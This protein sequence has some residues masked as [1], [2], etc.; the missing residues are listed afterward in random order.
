[1]YN[2]SSTKS[3]QNLTSD[4]KIPIVYETEVVSSNTEESSISIVPNE[5][6]NKIEVVQNLETI[7]EDAELQVTSFAIPETPMNQ[8]VKITS[9]Q[10]VELGEN[11]KSK[12][13]ETP[14]YTKPM[15]RMRRLYSRDDDFD[16]HSTPMANKNLN[17]PAL[18]DFMNVSVDLENSNFD[19]LSTNLNVTSS[20]VQCESNQSHGSFDLSKNPYKEIEKSRIRKVNFKDTIDVKLMTPRPEVTQIVEPVLPRE[21]RA[22]SKVNYAEISIEEPSSS[23]SVI[24][25]AKSKREKSK[26]RSENEN[27]P[28]RRK[29]NV[30][31]DEDKETLKFDE[32]RKNAI[33][34]ESHEK[35][36]IDEP[37]VAKDENRIVTDKSKAKTKAKPKRTVGRRGKGNVELEAS[38][39]AKSNQNTVNTNA[40]ENYENDSKDVENE[41]ELVTRKIDDLTK[42]SEAVEE[43]SFKTVEQSDHDIVTDGDKGENSTTETKFRGRGRGKK[44]IKSKAKENIVSEDKDIIIS[45]SK[46]VENDGK[47]DH[48]IVDNKG[49]NSSV[50]V[51]PT[52]S[53]GRGRGKKIVKS[54]NQV[55]V[56]TVS[57]SIEEASLQKNNKDTVEKKIETLPDVSKD[58]IEKSRGIGRGRKQPVQSTVVKAVEE[59][60]NVSKNETSIESQNVEIEKNIENF[61]ETIELP[62]KQQLRRGRRGKTAN[63]KITDDIP[64]S[65]SNDNDVIDVTKS[66]LIESNSTITDKKSVDENQQFEEDIIV[67]L[68]PIEPETK[69]RARPKKNSF[70]EVS[71]ANLESQIIPTEKTRE[72]SVENQD[73]IASDESKK[74]K[75]VPTA[76]KGRGRKANQINTQSNDTTD[77]IIVGKREET[78]STRTPNVEIAPESTSIITRKGKP[79]ANDEENIKIIENSHEIVNQLQVVE[80]ATKPV[81][82]LRGRAAK[83][84]DTPAQIVIQENAKE[85]DQSFT[86]K[87]TKPVPKDSRK[88]RG[89]KDDVPHDIEPVIVHNQDSNT[90]IQNSNT[91]YHH[92][93][94]T[95]TNT[96]TKGRG[97]KID[98]SHDLDSN[99]VDEKQELSA[100]SNISEN[101]DLVGNRKRVAAKGGR[102]ANKIVIK[103]QATPIEP[104]TSRNVEVSPTSVEEIKGRKGRKLIN[105]D[106]IETSVN[107]ESKTIEESLISL[108]SVPLKRA[109]K[110]ITEIALQ[111]LT[112]SSTDSP[113]RSQRLLNRNKTVDTESVTSNHNKVELADQAKVSHIDE[114]IT[115][116]KNNRTKRK[117]N[118][119]EIKTFSPPKRRRQ[120]TKKDNEKNTDADAV[121][122]DSSKVENSNSEIPEKNET[123]ELTKPIRTLRGRK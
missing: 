22:R 37:K 91:D 118:T 92:T 86:F 93:E 54:K 23:T 14:S 74:L 47:I 58:T 60:T 70:E 113:L 46:T 78:V 120:A 79:V 103:Q 2:P 50:E 38:T 53:R 8:N 94:S 63:K 77:E 88:G 7:S 85:Q 13:K 89:K 16:F 115:N 106:K 64:V 52:K 41:G 100:D 21:R 27:S 51:I 28:K 9:I 61:I 117:Q 4:L 11:S 12:N 48:D 73:Q 49:E 5:N 122:V 81:R 67:E 68:K 32:Q 71:H 108:E 102:G 34:N 6:L 45:A 39:K 30:N 65:S 20:I 83:L 82:K 56:N 101:I 90:Q 111:D 43:N 55:T 97:K 3:V 123:L 29:T 112:Q 114:N 76:R 105:K 104:T 98:V 75:K 17:K 107:S 24:V 99:L 96:K 44:I 95:K 35:I 110:G 80:P 109:R 18:K 57:T 1:M 33:G 31:I 87:S 19:N 59:K 42:V 116:A 15:R 10:L 119:N 25:N 26:D 62:I 84:A 72:K 66:E 36:I 121:K 69:K 40:L